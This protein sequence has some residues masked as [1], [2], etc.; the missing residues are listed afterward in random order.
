MNDS[1]KSNGWKYW[2]VVVGLLLMTIAYFVH[3]RNKVEKQRDAALKEADDFFNMASQ[4]AIVRL[5]AM[6]TQDS[7]IAAERHAKD[8]AI[9]AHAKTQGS[10]KTTI[11]A[12]K[13][14]Y[15][16]RPDTVRLTLA[17]TVIITQDSLIIDLEKE[18]AAV[19]ARFSD[20]IHAWEEKV[21]ISEAYGQAME[22][23]AYDQN[24]ART[25]DAKAFRR[26]RR[27]ERVIEGLIVAGVIVLSL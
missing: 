24:A 26:Q 16:L 12:L 21:R 9:V 2:L 22:K 11:R 17:D 7:I 27:K 6:A 18:K 8:S 25:E 4:E 3:D 1:K 14:R 23:M 20:E 19:W 5:G 10:L 15:K 13:D